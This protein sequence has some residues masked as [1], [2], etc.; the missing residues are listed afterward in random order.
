MDEE[1]LQ[2][3]RAAMWQRLTRQGKLIIER[4]RQGRASNQ[5]LCAIALKF[6]GR[7]SDL[8][9]DGW[10]IDLVEHNQA[11]GEAWYVL[12]QPWPELKTYSVDVSIEIPGQAVQQATLQIAAASTRYARTRAIRAITVTVTGDPR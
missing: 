12:S 6:T 7:I 8:R 4:L 1:T 3:E 11:T 9:R 2:Q 5:E 10:L